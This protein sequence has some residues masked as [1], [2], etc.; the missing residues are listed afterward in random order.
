M[1]P[2]FILIL[3]FWCLT[4]SLAAQIELAGIFTNNMV[5]QRDVEIPVW[6][7]STKGKII[8]LIFKNNTY[9]AK[10]DKTGKWQIK[11]P[12]TPAGGTY[13][14]TVTDGA[15]EK[16]LNN[17]LFGDVW[18]CSGQSNMEWTVDNSMFAQ[19]EMMNAKDQQ[20]RHFKVARNTSIVP[21]EKLEGS[22]WEVTSPETVG[23]FTAV[24]YQFA[25]SI[26]QHHDVPIGLLN[27]S[28][29]GSRIEP[30]MSAESLGYENFPKTAKAAQKKSDKVAKAKMA[31]FEAKF[32]KLPKQDAGL[33]NGNA[34]WA[35]PELDDS[36]WKNINAPSLWENQGLEGVDGIV[37]F[38]KTIELSADDIE[39]DIMLHLS[40][41]DDND[42]TYFN[43]QLIGETNQYS[44]ERIYQVPKSLLKA[45]ANVIAVRVEDTGG[46]GGFYG[47]S[48]EMYAQTNQQKISL[49]GTWKYKLGVIKLNT[50]VA[51][52]QEPV[53]IYN[54]MIY[55]I[56]NFPIKGV[57]WYQ[58]ESN[59][60]AEDAFV[61]RDLFATMIQDWR[62]RW[63]VGDFP[64]LYVQLANYMAVKSQPSAS[65]WAMLRESQM[66][67]LVLPN[68]AQ[69]VII[70]IGDANDI[71]PRNKH[72]VGYR[73][74]LGARKLAY[75][76]QNLVHNGPV[77]QSMKIEGNKIR[78]Q[79]EAVGGTL[80]VKGSDLKEFAIAGD[81]KKF[82]WANAKIEGNEII[83]WSDEVKNPVAVR[84]AWADNPHQA[85]LYNQQGL[86]ATP[87]RTDDW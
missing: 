64:F 53:I 4:N 55:P 76:E 5:L 58:G 7:W 73:L 38:R 83:V 79:F 18:V 87:F 78:L 63:G 31:A 21:T 27:T 15:S 17:I 23:K 13:Q 39:K 81:D 3:I 75:G 2:Y 42:K 1:K 36:Q 29:G 68:T 67:T 71:H 6:G 48:E 56:L 61:Y 45:G 24:G 59:A 77:Y 32:G 62:K 86:P 22:S 80:S 10:A 60:G 47:D 41:I 33:V 11:L 54:K 84:Y 12:P 72:D 70:D 44:R 85:N 35:V 49:A 69:A 51:S 66:K 14:M 37:W 74:A 43:G 65:N 50:G 82:V 16:T 9:Q 52:N 30:W 46:G 57:I 25:K 19:N 40:K 26:R 8:T 20:I 34:L 28:W